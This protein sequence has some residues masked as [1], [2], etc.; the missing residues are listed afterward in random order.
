LYARVLAQ[1]GTP[2]AL[3]EWDTKIPALERVVAEAD[4]IRGAVSR[5]EPATASVG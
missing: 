1:T 4:R 5:Q 2:P 3:F